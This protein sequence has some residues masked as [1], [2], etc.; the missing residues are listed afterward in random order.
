MTTLDQATLT[1]DM[2]NILER[3][4]FVLG[5]AAEEPRLDPSDYREHVRI[6]MASVNDKFLVH[7]SGDSGFLSEV[8]SS[9]LG[10][11]P[12]EVHPGEQGRQAL[13][14]LGN[15]VGGAVVRRLGGE[16]IEFDLGLPA[17]IEETLL[18]KMEKKLGEPVALGCLESED[19][20]L[21]VAVFP[22]N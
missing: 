3:M 19:G 14:E 2:V 8:A 21:R 20:Y 18:V 10:V 22:V 12:E 4:A 11:L 7:L 1:S 13:L 16:T 6:E 9:M 17:S 15:V 5:E